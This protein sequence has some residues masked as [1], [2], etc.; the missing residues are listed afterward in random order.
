[1]LNKKGFF[2]LVLILVI[3]GI[4]AFVIIEAGIVQ[5][6]SGSGDVSLKV[7]DVENFDKLDIS[8]PAKVYITQSKDYSV[9]L[10]AEDNL[11]PYIYAKV[12]RNTLNIK[13]KNLIWFRNTEP[14]NIYISMPEVKEIE[15]STSGNVIGENTISGED[16]SLQISGT[17][18][19]NMDV[20][21]QDLST[22]ISGT[23]DVELEGEAKN[24]KIKISGVG[25]VNCFNLDSEDVFVVISG[26]GDVDVDVSELLDVTI[27]G[28]G[29]VG[30]E[31]DP[32]I[33]RQI[34]G[35]GSI[36]SV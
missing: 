31:G 32:R 1:M 7:L 4:V 27:S 3:V 33:K 16:L 11:L 24:H 18:T 15:V 5:Y 19:I 6:I 36:R 13:R 25:D 26:A 21:V 28:T 22:F 12:E 34:S 23:G 9:I 29:S 17:G 14:I 8:V 20:K 10:E 2:H 30:Y 35:F